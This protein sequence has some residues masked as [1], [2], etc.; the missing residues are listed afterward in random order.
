MAQS[1]EIRA[2]R[3]H[4]S[5]KAAGKTPTPWCLERIRALYQGMK[6]KLFLAIKK[7]DKRQFRMR[8]S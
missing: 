4:P 1:R 7:N 6:D 8:W 3:N 2:I 5:R